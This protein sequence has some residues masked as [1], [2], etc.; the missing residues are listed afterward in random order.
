[1]VIAAF[2]VLWYAVHEL[3]PLKPFPNFARYMLPLAPLLV[4]TRH[5]HAPQD[6]GPRLRRM[7]Q[8]TS[9][10]LSSAVAPHQCAARG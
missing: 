7:R 2:A 4:H 3:S 10:Q 6:R 5:I 1:M 9:V 8:A